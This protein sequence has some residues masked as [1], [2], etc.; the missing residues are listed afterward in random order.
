MSKLD[1]KT[2]RRITTD[3]V[4]AT[5]GFQRYRPLHLLKRHGPILVGIYLK[6]SRDG[7][8]YYPTSHI[9]N[10]CI[11]SPALLLSCKFEC[12]RVATRSHD[13]VK[14]E[15]SLAELTGHSATISSGELTCDSVLQLYE[16]EVSTHIQLYEPPLLI[17][18]HWLSLLGAASLLTIGHFY[19][20]AT[21]IIDFVS[22]NVNHEHLP[23]NQRAHAMRVLGEVGSRG[24]LDNVID[25]EVASLGLAKLPTLS[26]E[27]SV[28]E[29][30]RLLAMLSL[31]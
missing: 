27:A 11:A 23:T 5:I 19:E 21:Q 30:S 26:F 3:W 25:R 4:D 24:N 17:A 16:R 22:S 7:K 8:E 29:P 6:P 9:H 2:K 10:L 14:V 12:S 31:I 1:A 18:R 28:A 20:P 15:R 13:M